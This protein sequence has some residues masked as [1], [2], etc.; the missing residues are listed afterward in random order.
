MWR[1][2]SLKMTF[3]VP[4]CG[5]RSRDPKVVDRW[6]E[7]RIASQS[8]HAKLLAK[9]AAKGSTVQTLDEVK[10]EAHDTTDQLE[11]VSKENSG[12]V[13]FQEDEKGVFVHPGNL[14]AH[15]KSCAGVV[16]KRAKT[17][18]V[19]DMPKVLNFRAKVVESLYIKG[20]RLHILNV[21]G[22]IVQKATGYRD[23]TLSVKTT[24]G[25]R[26]CLK[27]VDYVDPAVI[28]ATIQLYPGGEIT[29]DWIKVLLDYGCVQGF[30]QDRSLQYGQYDYELGE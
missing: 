28:E 30:G 13:G 3:T 16:G 26:T 2:L 8:H 29:R 25:P 27:R 24:Q 11:V 17:G 20:H 10:Q 12:W 7:T 15:F 18:D 14:R 5:S 19:P 23:A 4:L 9:A 1:E 21:D 6:L 22:T